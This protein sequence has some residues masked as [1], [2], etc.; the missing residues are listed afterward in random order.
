MLIKA[1]KALTA[2][3]IAVLLASDIFLTYYL[4]LSSRALLYTETRAITSRAAFSAPIGG[5]RV[6]S[7]SQISRRG[8]EA[9][10]RAFIALSKTDT[11]T[12]LYTTKAD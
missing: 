11:S 4:G 2:A 1:F 7:K 8:I 9:Y 5:W 6:I 10:I 12:I 3:Q